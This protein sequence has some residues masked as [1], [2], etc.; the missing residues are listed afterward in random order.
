M[1]MQMYV[2]YDIKSRVYEPPKFCLNE[3]TAKRLFIGAFG[4]QR[5]SYNRFPRDYQVYYIGT[6]DDLT[7]MIKHQVPEYKWLAYDLIKEDDANQ[8]M[9]FQKDQIT[10]QTQEK[11]NA[12]SEG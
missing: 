8:N 4:N 10:D 2:V 9:L 3:D 5:T 12:K 1:E 7:C 6:F 11:E